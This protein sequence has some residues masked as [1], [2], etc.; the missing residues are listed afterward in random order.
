MRYVLAILLIWPVF[1]F[2]QADPVM[3]AELRKLAWQEGPTEGR[4]SDKATITV[5]KQMVFLD[6]Q[7]TRRFLELN[8]NPPQDGNYLIAPTSL[9]WFAVFSF[10]GSGYIKDDEKI[11]PNALL[12]S[13]KDS[14][15]PANEERKRLGMMPLYT[16][17]WE[18]PP[19][20]DIVT[21]RLEWGMRCEWRRIGSQDGGAKGSQSIA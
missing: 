14:D 11:D 18:V 17:G 6:A 15:A 16:E 1:A 9:A 20:Y 12:K 4:I 3:M 7:N 21:K 10:R 13:L 19:H 5:P 8:G 2:G